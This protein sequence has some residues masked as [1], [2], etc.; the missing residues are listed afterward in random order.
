V[1]WDELARSLLASGPGQLGIIL[2]MIGAAAK[3]LAPYVARRVE[4]EI[5]RVQQTQEFHEKEQASELLI[6]ERRLEQELT[7]QRENREMTREVFNWMQSQLE[8]SMK[9]N[10]Q[11]IAVQAQ[12]LAEL[13]SMRNAITDMQTTTMKQQVAVGALIQKMPSVTE[14]LSVIERMDHAIAKNEHD[15]NQ[16]WSRI[17]GVTARLDED[18]QQQDLNGPRR[19]SELLSRIEQGIAERLAEAERKSQENS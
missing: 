12:M 3:W 13:T 4:F 14:V 1:T 10:E 17:R 18:M 7:A 5:Q 2:L 16:A 19:Q 6:T 8:V 15:I 11:N 9:Q